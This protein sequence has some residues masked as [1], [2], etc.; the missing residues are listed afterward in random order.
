MAEERY[1]IRFTIDFPFSGKTL[2]EYKKLDMETLYQIAKDIVENGGQ[3]TT[4]TD[5]QNGEAEEVVIGRINEIY[6][7][8]NKR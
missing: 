4:I 2:S 1:P 6:E 8:F 5:F 3:V 7:L